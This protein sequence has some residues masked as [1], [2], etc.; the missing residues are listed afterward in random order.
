VL[1]AVMTIAQVIGPL[2][3]LAAG[4]AL[5]HVWMRVVFLAIASG[6]SAAALAFSAAV[7]GG[8][9]GEEERDAR[10]AADLAAVLP[11]EARVD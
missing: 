7:R 9:A 11:V 3:F 10:P 5:Q 4:L 8:D 1:T 2:G 6:F